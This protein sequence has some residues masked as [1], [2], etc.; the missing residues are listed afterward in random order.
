MDSQEAA[1]ALRELDAQLDRFLRALER[2]VPRAALLV[3]LT[4][5]HG[6]VPIPEVSAAL[7]ASECRV[8][9]GRVRSKEFLARVEA[10]LREVCDTGAPVLVAYDHNYS[11][12][13]AP[14]FWTAAASACGKQR[15]AAIAEAAARLARAPAVVKVWTPADVRGPPAECAGMCRLYRNS[16]AG[17]RSGDLVVQL[18]PTCQLTD[19]P[20]GTGH[21][22][23]Y[24]Y[25]RN[26]PLV[27][28]GDG[29]R[30][31]VV[32]GEAH[33]TDIAPTLAGRLGVALPHPV[34]G[35]ALPL[36]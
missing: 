2:R 17:E 1:A 10:A 30:A 3:V 20:L 33:T 12:K 28:W 36:E 6:A 5:D 14:E 18:D 4:A 13:V 27:F 22:A 11:F 29:I 24:A 9:G 15:D 26:V 31:A 35:R 16:F 32:R 7:G 8:P 23:P 19:E 25:D 34:A 21:G